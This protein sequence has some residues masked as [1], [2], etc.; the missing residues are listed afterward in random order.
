MQSRDG[1]APYSRTYKSVHYSVRVQ[2]V[3]YS[4]GSMPLKH[5][6]HAELRA[7]FLARRAKKRNGDVSPSRRSFASPFFATASTH[8]HRHRQAI[9]ISLHQPLICCC[10]RFSRPR[11]EAFI[12]VIQKHDRKVSFSTIS[13]RKIGIH[14]RI[15][16]S[17]IFCYHECLPNEVDLAARPGPLVSLS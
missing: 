13:L 16:S 11:R 14:A 15:G 2:L 6:A 1:L 5:F 4:T 12:I 7:R 9:G 10:C 3:P 17:H 8:R